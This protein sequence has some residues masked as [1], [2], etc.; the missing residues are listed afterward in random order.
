MLREFNS[1]WA[2]NDYTSLKANKDVFLAPLRRPF[3]H[4]RVY[5]I[6]IQ[7]TLVKYEIATTSTI[8]ARVARVLFL[9]DTDRVADANHHRHANIGEP[10]APSL[11][12]HPPSAVVIN[13]RRTIKDSSTEEKVLTDNSTSEDT[14]NNSTGNEIPVGIIL[15]RPIIGKKKAKMLVAKAYSKGK[16]KALAFS[17]TPGVVAKSHAARLVLVKEERNVS[18]KRLALAAEAKNALLNQQLKFQ[19]DQLQFQVCMANPHSA[20][21]IAYF[22]QEESKNKAKNPRNVA[23][24]TPI[25][26]WYSFGQFRALVTHINN[27]FL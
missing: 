13:T 17:L 2:M 23:A 26:K 20:E 10:A 16:S 5:D 22:G 11:C 15:T 9:M 24:F 21:S 25:S 6:V 4:E 7:R 27:L 18:L 8:D 14:N 1:G 12:C 19:N 3:K